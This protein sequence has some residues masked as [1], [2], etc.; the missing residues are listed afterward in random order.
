MLVTFENLKKNYLEKIES[1]DK[2]EK[3]MKHCIVAQNVRK[4]DYL[5]KLL[6]VIESNEYFEFHYYSEEFFIAGKYLA[7]QRVKYEIELLYAYNNKI[8]QNNWVVNY[9]NY[10]TDYILETL[11]TIINK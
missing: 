6:N 8:L 3:N 2:I 7:M 9:D 11:D 4:I 10:N 1:A 5:E